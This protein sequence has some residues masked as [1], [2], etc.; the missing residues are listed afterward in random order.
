MRLTRDEMRGKAQT[1]LGL[2]VPAD[3]G[4][5]LMHEHLIWDITHPAKRDPSL[6]DGPQPGQYWTS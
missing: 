3:L 6:T 4:P 5:T 1:V 2:V